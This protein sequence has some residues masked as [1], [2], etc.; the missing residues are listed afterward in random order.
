MET[1]RLL[2]T[3]TSLVSRGGRLHGRY[4]LAAG[5]G[6]EALEEVVQGHVWQVLLVPVGSAAPALLRAYHMAP[7][8]TLLASLWRNESRAILKLSRRAHP[9][10]PVLRDTAFLRDEELAYLIID[11][12]GAPLT[13]QPAVVDALR[14]SRARALRAFLGLVDAAAVLH[15]EGLIHRTVTPQAIGAL[16]DGA[17]LRLDGFQMSTFVTSWLRGQR[18]LRETVGGP[19]V[20]R[21]ETVL[22]MLAPERIGPLFGDSVQRLEGFTEDVFGLGMVGIDWFAGPPTAA[23]ASAVTM[24]GRYSQ[25]RHVEFIRDCHS[26]LDRAELPLELR[27]LLQQM[28]EPAAANRLPSAMAVHEALSRMYAPVL[29]QFEESAGGVRREPLAVYFLKESVERLY[30]DCCVR[31][32]V[33]HM[34]EAEYARFIAEDLEGGQVTWSPRGF[35]PWD[36]ANS[37]EAESARIVLLGKRYTWFCQYLNQ[38]RSDEDRRVLL[39]KYVNH[40]QRSRDLRLQQRRA[41][42]PPVVASFYRPGGRFRPPVTGQ[43]WT[44]LVDAVR[45]DGTAAYLSPVYVTAEWLLGIHQA[46]L[47]AAEYPFERVYPDGDLVHPGEARPLILRAKRREPSKPEDR[48]P[49]D[50]FFDLLQREGLV[51][52]MGDCFKRTNEDEMERDTRVDFLIRDERRGEVKLRL[53]FK[54]RRDADTVEFET[55]QDESLIPDRGFVRPYDTASVAVLGRQRR[56]V[57]ALA[58]NDDLLAQLQEPLAYGVGAPDELGRLH[59]GIED[60]GTVALIHRILDSWPMFVLQGPPGTGKTFVASHVVRAVLA[61]EPLVRVLV[62]AQSNDALDNILETVLARLEERKSGGADASATATPILL[63]VAS[64]STENKVS[65]KARSYLAAKVTDDACNRVKKLPAGPDSGALRT[66][67]GQ[68][69]KAAR[70]TNLDAEMFV[71]VQRGASLVFATS[72]GA[73]AATDALRAGEGFDWVVSEESAHEW[74]HEVAVPLVQG[75]RWFLIGDQAQLQAFAFTEIENLLRRDINER[76]TEQAGGH[77]VTDVHRKYLSYFKHLMDVQLQERTGIEP[78][79]MIDEQRRMHPE[80]GALISDAFYY[81][82]GKGRLGTHLDAKRPHGLTAPPFIEDTALVWLDTSVYGSAAYEDGRVNN[83]EVKLIKYLVGRIGAFP[84]HEDGKA[85]VVILSPYRKQL[86]LLKGHIDRL[87]RE[88]F[89]SVDSFQGREAEVVIVSLVRNNAF[90]ERRS[91]LG[92][93]DSPERANVMFSRAR[94]LL[95]I[96]GSLAHFEKF[97]DTHWKR[98]IEYVRRDPKFLVDPRRPP[99]SFDIN[100][101]RSRR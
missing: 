22:A 92:F 91:A 5:A 84:D 98:V 66:I 48:S 97:S 13:Q 89:H 93:M 50:A 39:V 94:R 60:R 64:G 96:V 4:G 28:T 15:R 78:R 82:D 21:D 24:G 63:R 18:L 33:D 73:G 51:P 67:Q 76:A 75:D 36:T 46:K 23:L 68:W 72:A 17:S 25:P 11:D 27:R 62:S 57:Q 95:V 70:D 71:R 35:A 61:L 16:D 65:E 26:R 85:P 9:N 42:I 77:Q 31:N 55:T 69:A 81:K 6:P 99:F 32:D 88:S 3:V 101:D 14:A 2:E 19:F 83:V 20:P 87:P 54:E 56:A 40:P 90:D 79:H 45:F 43:P 80:I 74:L 12:P 52:P 7:S 58:E 34:D 41:D 86:Q 29:A 8:E 30:R 10:L 59:L 47:D 1:Q 44:D 53:H 38:A 37:R 49:R 100:R